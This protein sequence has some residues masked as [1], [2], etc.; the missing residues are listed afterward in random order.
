[1]DVESTS[2]VSLKDTTVHKNVTPKF[3]LGNLL[4][5]DLDPVEG[6]VSHF[7]CRF[8]TTKIYEIFMSC[9]KLDEQKLQTVARDN[10]QLLINEIWKVS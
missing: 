4:I 9:S 6:W 5:E 10:V 3:D 2:D 1:M 8:L 7:I